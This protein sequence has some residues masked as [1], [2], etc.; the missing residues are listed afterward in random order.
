[1]TPDSPVHRWLYPG[2]LAALALAVLAGGWLVSGDP[3]VGL[4]MMAPPLALAVIVARRRD[5]EEV[6]PPQDERQR[7]LE[8]SAMATGFVAMFVVALAGMVW[9]LASGLPLGEL[10][11]TGVLLVGAVAVM[12][13][14]LVLQ[15]RY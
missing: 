8:R 12:A 6:N 4:T 15:R 1:M 5:S 2:L 3:V 9:E 13:A 11:A 10:R 7:L 14:S